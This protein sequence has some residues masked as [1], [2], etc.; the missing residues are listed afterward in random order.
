M[1]SQTVEIG[2]STDAAKVRYRRRSRRLSIR[3]SAIINCGSCY[4]R[5]L[6]S[7]SYL[8]IFR[9]TAFNWLSVITTSARGL[10]EGNGTDYTTLSNL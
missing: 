6:P 10:L 4:F 7:S 1:S 5:Q 3:L 8:T 9:C 2:G